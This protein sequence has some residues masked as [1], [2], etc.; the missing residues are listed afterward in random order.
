MN[1]AS[2]SCIQANDMI[3]IHTDSGSDSKIQP[4]SQK[5]F[6]KCASLKKFL[7]SCGKDP[8]PDIDMNSI[9]EIPC[10]TGLMLPQ[11]W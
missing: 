7:S 11:G 1:N 3:E 2:G 4:F 8:N 6:C 10:P 9:P 5:H